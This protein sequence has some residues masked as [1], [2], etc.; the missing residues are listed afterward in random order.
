MLWSRGYRHIEF[1]LLVL[2]LI[3]LGIAHFARVT[4]VQQRQI[5]LEE[6]LEQLYQLERVFFQEHGRYFDPTDLAEGLE[7][8]WME[9]FR[10]EVR[11]GRSSFLIIVRADLDG[12]REVGVWSIDDRN[13]TVRQLVED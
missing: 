3:G 10:W 4:P 9:N 6:G 5:E 8:K 13:P 2:V 12:D 11:A 7:W 1:A